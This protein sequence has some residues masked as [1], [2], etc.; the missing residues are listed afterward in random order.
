MAEEETPSFGLA[1]DQLVA[2]KG[3]SKEKVLDTIEHAIAAAYRKD[4]GE[5][6]QDIRAEFNEEDGSTR[7][8]KVVTVV[9]DV[10]E[11]KAS[12]ADKAETDDEH[13]DEERRDEI[14]PAAQITLTEA[15]KEDKKAKVGKEYVEEVTPTDP[16]YGRVAAQTAK[17]VI[18]QRIRDNTISGPRLV[19][20]TLTTNTR[21]R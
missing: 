2:E 6:G 11:D 10:V 4:N 15:K 7:I 20:S 16:N 21:I 5:R 18:I 3:I 9:E 1:I 12:D 19:N 17:Q 14:N 8:F 13:R